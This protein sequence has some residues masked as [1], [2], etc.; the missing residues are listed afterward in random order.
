M[1]MHEHKKKGMI[2][3]RSQ[4][5]GRE[6]AGQRANQKS[7]HRQRL[8]VEYFLVPVFGPHFKPVRIV[9]VQA[10]LFTEEGSDLILSRS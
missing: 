8:V 5:T 3:G 7:I 2:Q 10:M 6:G 9:G 1:H 4:S